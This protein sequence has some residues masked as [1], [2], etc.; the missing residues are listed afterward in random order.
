MAQRV[1][2]AEG[3]RT[4]A[5]LPDSRLCYDIYLDSAMTQILK[6]DAL[7]KIAA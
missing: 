7:G 6:G 2:K 5:D 4:S 1:C 3:R